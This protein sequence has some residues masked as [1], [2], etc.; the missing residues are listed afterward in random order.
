[1]KKSIELDVII[2]RGEDGYFIGTVPAL[3]SCY[4]QAKTLPELYK[5]LEEVVA[6]CAEVEK[7][8]FT[9]KIV[10]PKMIGFQ[11]MSFSI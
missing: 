10:M 6:L 5:N 11:R 4:T 7:E 9:Q 3:R 1:M 8:F 2:E